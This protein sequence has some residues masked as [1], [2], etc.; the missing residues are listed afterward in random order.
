MVN[1]LNYI[2]EHKDLMIGYTLSFTNTIAIGFVSFLTHS[3]STIIITNI[4]GVL[5]SILTIVLT[6]KAIYGIMEQKR[7]L[8]K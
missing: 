8:K 4:V 6:V 2:H 5:T 3:E 1:F 7:R